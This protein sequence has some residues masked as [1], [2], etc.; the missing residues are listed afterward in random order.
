MSRRRNPRVDAPSG[1]MSLLSP[2]SSLMN[3]SCKGGEI[4][5]HCTQTQREEQGKQKK[6]D[7]GLEKGPWAECA[8]GEGMGCLEHFGQIL[9]YLKLN[10]N[11][12][13]KICV[14]YLELHTFKG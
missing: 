6:K 8:F 11:R 7:E 10:L 3:P 12:L 9:F 2:K 5:R 14:N 1:L 13:F 4:H